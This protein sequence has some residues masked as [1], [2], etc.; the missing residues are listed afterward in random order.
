MPRHGE[1]VADL[2]LRVGRDAY[3]ALAAQRDTLARTYRDLFSRPWCSLLR[4]R[5]DLAVAVAHA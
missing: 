3:D 5:P 1:R 2:A 4:Y